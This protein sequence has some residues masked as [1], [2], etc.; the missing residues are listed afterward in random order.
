MMKEVKRAID[1][2]LFFHS[3]MDRRVRTAQIE[4]WN[5]GIQVYT[6]NQIDYHLHFQSLHSLQSA[7]Q[8]YT[9]W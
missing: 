1:M 5:P 2:V 4:S 3:F 7:A 9:N 6:N 8:R